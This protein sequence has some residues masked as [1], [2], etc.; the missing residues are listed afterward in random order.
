[1][2]TVNGEG[3]ENIAGKNITEYLTESGYDIKRV[4]VELN[5]DILP[6]AQYENTVLQDGDSVEIVSFVGG[7]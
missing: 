6:K 5:G 2:I 1:M 4:A 3:I 7:G